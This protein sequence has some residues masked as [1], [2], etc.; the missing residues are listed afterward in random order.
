MPLTACRECGAAIPAH[1]HACPRCG[2]RKGSAAPAGPVPPA[3]SVPP[4]APAAYRPPPRRPQEPERSRWRTAAGWATVVALFAFL[5]LFVFRLSREADQRALEKDEVAR[6]A[7]HLRQVSAWMQDTTS[8]APETA[9]WPV[10]ASAR[11]RRMWVINRMLVDR[12]VWELEVQARHGVKGSSAPAAWATPPY[13]ANARSYPE[14]G[15]YV[16][17][18]VAALAEIDKTAAAWMEARTAVLARESGMPIGEVRA[19]FPPDFA[20]AALDEARLADAMLKGHR[21]AVRMDPRVDHGGGDQLLWDRKEDVD[22]F[23]ELVNELN[24]ATVHFRQAKARRHATEVA[25]LVP[26]IL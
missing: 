11:A 2:A 7:E 22:R 20:R 4:V 8:T 5:G 6:E 21:Q 12:L 15:A 18:R 13:W 25:A 17:G 19:I 14:V 23:K 9:D 1:S 26:D 3:G 10:P 24:A 16:E